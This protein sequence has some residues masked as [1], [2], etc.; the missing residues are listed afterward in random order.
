MFEAWN[1][2]L[3]NEKDIRN[4]VAGDKTVGYEFNLQYP[5]YRGT[6]LSCIEALEVTVD[7]KRLD[8]SEMGFAVNGKEVL[9]EEFPELFREYWFTLDL[10]TIRVY[11]MGGLDS[12]SRHRIS[13]DLKHRIPYTGY[14]GNYMVLDSHCEKELMVA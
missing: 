4:I 13:V 2:L 3:V 9:I 11:S 14:F 7:G 12:G 10:A 8:N 5:S 1:R 6:F